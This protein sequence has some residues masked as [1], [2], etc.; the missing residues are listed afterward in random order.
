MISDKMSMGSCRS[1]MHLEQF[2][3][4]YQLSGQ[5]NLYKQTS[6][7]FVAASNFTVKRNLFLY[8]CH[9]S[10]TSAPKTHHHREPSRG[11]YG[12]TLPKSIYMN[13]VIRTSGCGMEQVYSDSLYLYMYIYIYVILILY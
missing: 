12:L 8:I 4:K 7:F 9:K 10:I 6:K 11:D 1:R 2:A 5:L 3:S 13:Q